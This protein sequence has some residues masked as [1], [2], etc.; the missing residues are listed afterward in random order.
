[1]QKRKIISLPF[2]LRQLHWLPIQ[3]QIFY[4]I[5]SATHGS[6]QENTPL[7]PPSSD[8]LYRHIPSCPL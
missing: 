5:L 4:K 1:M 7:P 8:L 3:K 6:V 2:L